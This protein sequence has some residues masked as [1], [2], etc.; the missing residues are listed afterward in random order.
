MAL[1]APS[2][3]VRLAPTEREQRP[4]GTQQSRVPAWT[5][6]TRP[7]GQL[8]SWHVRPVLEEQEQRWLQ[9]EVSREEFTYAQKGAGDKV[10]W[11]AN[12]ATTFHPLHPSGVTLQ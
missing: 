9:S 7:S 2:K 5:S 12:A 10:R 8:A 1:W 11:T 4:W 3:V 6:H